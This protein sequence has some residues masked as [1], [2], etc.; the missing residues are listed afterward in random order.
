MSLYKYPVVSVFNL[1]DT[2]YTNSV[3]TYWPPIRTDRH[4]CINDLW[5]YSF[6][7]LLKYYISNFVWLVVEVLKEKKSPLRNPELYLSVLYVV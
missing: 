7:R 4:G 3:C 1:K 5:D 2:F 6:C